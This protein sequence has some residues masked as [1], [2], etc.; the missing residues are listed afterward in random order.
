M[1]LEGDLRFAGKRAAIALGE[2]TQLLNQRFR[3][4]EAHG[5]LL[6]AVG[7]FFGAR[8]AR[9]STVPYIMMAMEKWPKKKINGRD[10]PCPPDFCLKNKSTETMKSSAPEAQE[11]YN[12][13]VSLIG[14]DER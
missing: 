6:V 2:D 10:S 11:V 8:H 9:H 4:P 5:F 12:K 1:A 14:G 7:I 13:N 3:Q